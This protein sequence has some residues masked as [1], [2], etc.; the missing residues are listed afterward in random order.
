MSDEVKNYVTAFRRCLDSSS[1]YA[2][3]VGNLTVRLDSAL[4]AAAEAI[5]DSNEVEDESVARANFIAFLK[6][7]GDAAAQVERYHAESLSAFDRIDT[8]A[9]GVL[10]EAGRQMLEA[11]FAVWHAHR[12]LLGAMLRNP[13]VAAELEDSSEMR[14]LIATRAGFNLHEELSFSEIWAEIHEPPV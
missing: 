12:V 2:T 8:P 13:E 10:R 3:M 11:E 6:G 5:G 4:I 9:A 14:E 7:D 1:A